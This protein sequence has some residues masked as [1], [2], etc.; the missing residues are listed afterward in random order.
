MAKRVLESTISKRIRVAVAR[1]GKA[2]V[3]RNYVGKVVPWAA[4]DARPVLAGLGLGSADLVG[5]LLG[6]GRAIALEVKTERG[7]VG[8][9][10]KLWLN[11]FRKRGGFA[12]VVRSPEEAVAAI[13]RACLGE[14]E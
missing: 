2:V 14:N 7:V 12:C 4:P 10:Q 6:S 13:E 1:T 8:D 5:M 9:D 11:A 3:T